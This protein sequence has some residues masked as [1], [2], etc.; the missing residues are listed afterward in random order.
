MERQ[1]NLGTRPRWVGQ[2][3]L[4]LLELEAPADSVNVPLCVG[5]D[6]GVIQVCEAS[7]S[8]EYCVCLFGERDRSIAKSE[9]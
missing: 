6:Y 3:A 8:S 7:F 4:K 9:R 5:E 2:R 1:D